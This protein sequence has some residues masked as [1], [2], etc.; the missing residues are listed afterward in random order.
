MTDDQKQDQQSKPEQTP[1]EPVP[2]PVTRSHTVTVDG[3]ALSYTT[4]AGLMPI[5]DDKGEEQ[6]RLY[7]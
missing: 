4:T 6:A 5:H 7:W 3:E 2:E 1:P